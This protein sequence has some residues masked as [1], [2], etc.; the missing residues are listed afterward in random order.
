MQNSGKLA[1]K[2]ALITGGARGLGRAYALRLASLGADIGIIDI[3]LKSYEAFEE[4]KKLMTADTTVEEVR[5]LGRR[6]CG[7]EADVSDQKQ[8]LEAVKIVAD[9]LGEIDIL[10]ANAGGGIGGPDENPASEMNIDHYHTMIN[11]NIH[12]TVYTV[13]A[14]APMMKKKKSGK[15]VTVCSQAGL[16][17]TL[18]GTFAHYGLA[19]AAVQHY[20]LY[21]SADL[22]QYGINVN[23]IAPGFI[24]TG[25]IKK[26]FMES[27]K[28]D[29]HINETSLRRYG[30]PEE[31]AK[32]VEFLCT[33]LSDFV[34]G[35]TIE[36]TGGT[37]GKID[38]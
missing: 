17:T 9:E 22:G 32:V 29:S 3:D 24:S 20:T 1:G 19:K 23:C 14:V 8:V 2:V 26:V 33:D 5:A 11:R 12:S 38:M 31:C 37:I 36:I 25:R 27:P 16:G 28:H 13:Q 6:S 10:V 7:V 30:T 4:E 15:I 18:K 35:A 34:T 21:L